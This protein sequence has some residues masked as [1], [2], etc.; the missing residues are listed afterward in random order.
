MAESEDPR[1]AILT[2]AAELCRHHASQYAAEPLIA[3]GA[4]GAAG[5]IENVRDNK[6]SNY[7]LGRLL[8]W[9]KHRPKGADV[10]RSQERAAPKWD[11]ED[12]FLREVRALRVMQQRV[13][14][15]RKDFMCDV[16]ENGAEERTKQHFFLALSALEQAQRWLKKAELEQERA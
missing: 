1:Y 6:L 12:L 8:E 16:D 9:Q 15:L 11:P 3:T 5:L 10:N 2:E 7:Q 13:E 4:L 14:R